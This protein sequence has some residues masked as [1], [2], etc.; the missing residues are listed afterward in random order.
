MSEMLKV[1]NKRAK[2]GLLESRS[3]EKEMLVEPKV[4]KRVIL[5]IYT[6][7]GGYGVTLTTQTN[8][9]NHGGYRV[10]GPKLYGQDRTLATFRMEVYEIDRLISELKAAKKFLTKKEKK[11]AKSKNV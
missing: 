3:F 6:A 10:V 5:D 8:R 4:D 1:L 9:E 11:N 2:K 7:N